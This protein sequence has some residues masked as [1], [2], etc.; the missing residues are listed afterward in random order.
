MDPRD[1]P[2]AV[3][4]PISRCHLAWFG[5]D[6]LTYAKPDAWSRLEGRPAR[7]PRVSPVWVRRLDAQRLRRRLGTMG[8][9]RLFLDPG[10][11]ELRKDLQQVVWKAD[12][13]GNITG[14]NGMVA[15]AFAGA[16]A[17]I[18]CHRAGAPGSRC[19]ILQE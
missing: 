12:V 4:M 17:G 9:R 7:S 15:G 1:A 14:D 3:R 13:A 2:N 5:V 16:G 11:N 18:R 6:E 8:E 10:C 19:R